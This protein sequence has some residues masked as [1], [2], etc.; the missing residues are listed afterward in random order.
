MADEDNTVSDEMR[1]WMRSANNSDD[2]DTVLLSTVGSSNVD[3]WLQ[4][5]SKRFNAVK[6]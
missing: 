4:V 5:V 3:L 2:N 6:R 1:Y